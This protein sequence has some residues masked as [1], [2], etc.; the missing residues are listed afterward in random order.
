[1]VF[2]SYSSLTFPANSS[3]MYHTSRYL[4]SDSCSP[5]SFI[6]TVQLQFLLLLYPEICSHQLT[7][8]RPTNQEPHPVKPLTAHSYLVRFGGLMNPCKLHASMLSGLKLCVKPRM[9]WV[10]DYSNPGSCNVQKALHWF[11]ISGSYNPS[12]VSSLMSPSFRKGCDIL[13]VAEYSTGG[14]GLI[15]GLHVF[16]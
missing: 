10:H 5:F 11:L 9:L 1:M 8:A 4:S 15:S 13:F 7:E 12:G 14:M 2:W 3:Q 16:G 6:I